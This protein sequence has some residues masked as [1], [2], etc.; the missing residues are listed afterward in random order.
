MVDVDAPPAGSLPERRRS[1]A[2]GLAAAS[3]VAALAATV[4]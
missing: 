1:L 3:V 4:L 2:L